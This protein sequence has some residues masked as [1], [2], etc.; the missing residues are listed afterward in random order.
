MSVA[1]EP[2]KTARAKK[3]RLIAFI[4]GALLLGAAGGYLGGKSLKQSG[5]KLDPWFL[6]G[7]P[8]ALWLVIAWHELGHLLGGWSSGFRFALF[9]VGPLRIDRVHDRIRVGWNRSAAL[10]GGVAASTPVGPRSE[11]TAAMRRAMM[12]VVAGGPLLSLIGTA[13]LIPASMLLQSNPSLAVLLGLS[14]ALSLMIA[15]ATFYPNSMGG[16]QSDGARLMQLWRGGEEAERWACL[17]SISGLSMLRRP[18]DWP[19]ELVLA[20]SRGAVDSND[21][22]SAAW[23]RASWH[24]DRG[25]LPEASE[26]VSRALEA[27]EFWP[28]PARPLLHAT[29]AYIR[30]RMGDATA[31]RAHLNQAMAPGFLEKEHRLL[32]EA[33]VLL[34]EGKASEARSIAGKAL[35]ELPESGEAAAATREKLLRLSNEAAA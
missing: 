12:R 16:F 23:L 10:W 4:L 33:A 17:A 9:A 15:L 28:K 2:R 30:A 11:S 27:M 26:W 3:I 34:A 1:G 19:E 8:L 21:G 7:L 14:G 35:Q 13:L 18:R 29:A 5:V 20:G 22:V 32:A 25:E 6:A 31:A 24:E